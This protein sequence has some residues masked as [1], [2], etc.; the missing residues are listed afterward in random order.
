MVSTPIAPGRRL[1]ERQTLGLD[2]LRIVVG[3]DDVDRG[4][5]QRL[6]QSEALVLAAQGGLSFRKVR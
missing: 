6:D 5:R 2:V 4:R 3:A 1:G